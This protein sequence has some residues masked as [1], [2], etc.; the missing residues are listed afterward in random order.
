LQ[1]VLQNFGA[2]CSRRLIHLRNC[3]LRRRRASDI[4]PDD[5]INFDHCNKFKPLP[6]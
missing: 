3:C 6:Q 2:V 5:A 1:P 4:A